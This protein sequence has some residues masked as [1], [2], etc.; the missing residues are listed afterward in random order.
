MVRMNT[1][2]MVDGLELEEQRNNSMKKNCMA[3]VTM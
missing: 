1:Q 2:W 3:K